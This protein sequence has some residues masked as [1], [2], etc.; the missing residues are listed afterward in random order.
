VEATKYGAIP[1][2]PLDFFDQS[3]FET[4]QILQAAVNKRAAERG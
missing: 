2:W 3:Q 4:E 1:D